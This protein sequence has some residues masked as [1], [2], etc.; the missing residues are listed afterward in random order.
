MT[1]INNPWVWTSLTES[2]KPERKE[3]T[4]VPIQYMTKGH[5]EYFPYSSWIKKGYVKRKENI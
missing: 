4:S 1:T 5:S 2:M 3:N